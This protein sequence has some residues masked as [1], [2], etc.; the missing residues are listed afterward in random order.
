MTE[1]VTFESEKAVVR[2]HLSKKTPEEFRENL[3]SAAR[4]FYSELKKTKVFENKEMS[5]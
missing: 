5:K 1:V 4:K 3:E 2:V